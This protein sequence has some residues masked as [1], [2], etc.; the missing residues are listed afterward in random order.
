[1]IKFQNT[2]IYF[3]I[4]AFLLF[5]GVFFYLYYYKPQP[6]LPSPPPSQQEPSQT[7]PQNEMNPTLVFFYANWCGHCKKPEMQSAWQETE[8]ML[9]GKVKTLKIESADPSVGR[10]GIT[11]FPTIR[12]YPDGIENPSKY[13]VFSGNRH[14]PQALANFAMSGGQAN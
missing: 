11:G 3:I 6:S 13:I 9:N 10:H 5:V 2:T 1:M 4:G 8:R 14:S 7:P 12:L